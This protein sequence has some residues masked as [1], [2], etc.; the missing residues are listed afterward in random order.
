MRTKSLKLGKAISAALFVLLLS[1]VGLTNVLAQPTGAINGLFSVREDLQVY[2][3]QGNLQ[4]QAS[5][6][7]WRFAENQWDYVG[8]D[9]ANISATYDGWIDLFGWGTSGYDH[10]AVCYQ[11][12]STNDD[13]NNYCAYGGEKLYNLYDQTGQADWGYNAISNGG[14]AEN[15]GWRTL[16]REEWDY[17]LNMR[18]TTSGIRWAHGC[19]NGVNGIIILPDNWTASVYELSDTNGGNYGSNTITTEDWT[20]VLEVNGAVFLPAAGYRYEDGWG[21]GLQALGEMG[22]YWSSS[23]ANSSWYAYSE[24]FDNEG[25]Y[26]GYNYYRDQGSSVRLIYSFRIN[27]TSNPA[28]GGT[29]SGSGAYG[30]GMSCTLTARANRGYTFVNWTE[31]GEVVSTEATYSFTVTGNRNLVANFLYGISVV[32]M[33]ENS[34]T[35]S[36]V[37]MN[38]TESLD[39]NFD[40]NNGLQGWTTIDADGDGDNWYWWNAIAGPYVVSHS[41]RNN[42]VLY[43]DNYL[44]SPSVILGGSITFK[45]RAGDNAYAAEHFGIA[46]STTGTNADDFT[47]VEEWT[48]TAKAVGNWYEYTVDLSSFNGM[49]YVAIRHFN[50]S[51][52][53][54]LNVDDVVITMPSSLTMYTGGYEEGQT[55][56]LTAIPNVGWE[57]TNWMENGVEVST[58]ATYSFTVD[59]GRNIVANFEQTSITQTT[60]FTTGWNWWSSYVELSDNS[61]QSLQDGLDTSGEMV[62]SQ[63]D[64]YASYLD[65]YGWYGSLVSIN[66]ESTYQVRT[67]AACSVEL[68]GSAANPESHPITLNSGWN[69]VGYPMNASMGVEDALSGIAPQNGDMLKSQNNGFAS[70]LDGFGWYGSLNTLNPGM[71]LMFNSNNSSAVTLVYPNGASRAELKANQTTDNNHWQ[72]NLNAYAD[73][74][75]VMAV[76]ELDGNELLGENYELAAFANDEVR[77]SAR[78]LYVEPLNRYMAFL[79]VAGDEACELRFRLYNAETGT[80][81]ETV[82]TPSLQ[83]EANAIVGSFAEPY[84]VSFRNSTGTDEWASSLQVFPNPVERG[85]TIS[86][87]ISAVETLRAT[88]VQIINALGMVVETL[89][90]TSLHRI[91]V[92]ET[93]G[94]YTLRITVEG[95]GTC[96]RKLLVK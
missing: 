37:G 20:N 41:W 47:M 1:V 13:P 2:F 66:N 84:V 38:E 59:G 39:F 48:M 17:V 26:L 16:T 69:W 42:V 74:M 35:V 94:V 78:L 3:S 65:G 70:Y 25:V 14:N 9:N 54:A 76:V 61:L 11:P 93:A 95:K 22:L 80:V 6:N 33:P 60:N 55:C 15:S 72:P 27:A 36:G 88:S 19:V 28:E 49:G 23:T 71:G 32:V 5:T 57:F 24:I 58:E 75:T 29:V 83:Y 62:K 67:N 64:G 86:L 4:Y 21:G 46:I 34:G 7:T 52:M 87:G 30:E 10:G 77:G 92:P 63:N 73:N 81:V 40:F 85:Q 45:A 96:H 90:A 50:C 18:N 79:T 31:N 12:W 43:P 56:S 44:V 51:D 8:E 53:Y 68:M 91:T 82:C 89:H